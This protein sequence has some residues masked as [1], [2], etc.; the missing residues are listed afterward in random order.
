MKAVQMDKLLRRNIAEKEETYTQPWVITVFRLTRGLGA[1]R[2][3]G[4]KPASYFS[5]SVL[6]N[7][8][9]IKA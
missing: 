4:R 5:V 7:A 1:V 8:L 2:D 6:M 9:K 3:T